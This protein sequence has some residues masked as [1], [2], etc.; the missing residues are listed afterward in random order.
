[1]HRF[2]YRLS[3][4][5]MG[6]EVLGVPVLLLTTVGRRSGR[7]RTVPLMY[8]PQGSRM[9]VVASNAA[10]PDQPPGWWFNLQTRPEAWVQL[11]GTRHRAR[12]EALDEHERELLWPRLAEH[13]PSWARYQSETGRRF[14]VIALRLEDS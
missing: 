13:N 2:F 7:E 6:G 5:R 14:P 3:G 12:A 4:G 10:E 11:G 8:Y 1:M 9:L